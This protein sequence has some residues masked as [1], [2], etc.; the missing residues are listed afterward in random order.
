SRSNDRRFRRICPAT[1]VRNPAEEHRPRIVNGTVPVR[2]LPSEVEDRTSVCLSP[3]LPPPGN[4]VGIPARQFL[5]HA[6]FRL[7]PNPDEAFM[8]ALI[9]LDVLRHPEVMSRWLPIWPNNRAIA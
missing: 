5:G 8:R 3:E 1:C 4:P 7:R 6:S 9:F 2:S